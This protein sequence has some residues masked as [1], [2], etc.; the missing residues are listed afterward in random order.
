[1]IAQ[2]QMAGIVYYIT[3]MEKRRKAF[4][5]L[6]FRRYLKGK[7]HEY[8]ITGILAQEGIYHYVMKFVQPGDYIMVSGTISARPRTYR[9]LHSDVIFVA[10]KIT[11]LR[12]SQK[13]RDEELSRVEVDF[14]SEVDV[15]DNY[16]F[17]GYDEY[18]EKKP[19][20][21]NPEEYSYD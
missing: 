20:K 6:V 14:D 15:Y 4:L 17:E 16:T 11:L 5:N 2:F 21:E 19:E 13:R 18:E 10:E 8:K 9:P 12:R 1:M 7:A 3:D